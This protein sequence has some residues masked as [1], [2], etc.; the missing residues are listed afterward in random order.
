MKRLYLFIISASLFLNGCQ[1]LEDA[2]P[3]DR[4][5]FMHFYEGAYSMTASAAEATNDG[6]IIAGNMEI[7][8]AMRTSRVIVIKTDKLGRKQWQTTV[9]NGIAS[10]LKAI[11]GGYAIIGSEVTYRPNASDI[12]EL[13]NHN[14]R[15]I[16]INE[17]GS[18]VDDIVSTPRLTADSK[19]IDYQGNGITLDENLN[20]I[21]LGTYREPGQSSFAYVAVINPVTLDTIWSREY[22]YMARDYVNTRSVYFESGQIIWGS[23]INENINAFN[24]SYLAFPV[25]RPNSTF[26][27]SNYYGQNDQ[28]QSLKIRDI[29]K[30]SSG[31]AAIGTYSKPDGKNADIFFIRIDRS[32][33]FIEGSVRYYDV[34]NTSSQTPSLS[35]LSETGEAITTTRDGGFVLAGTLTTDEGKGIGNGG[36]DVWIIKIDAFGEVEWSRIIGGKTNEAVS[37]ILETEDG[38]LLICGTIQ[39]GSEQS[40]GLSSIFLVKTNRYGELKD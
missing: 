18:V 9:D 7:G 32:G 8:G 2:A 30:T 36:K 14:S 37:S 35:D 27:N 3:E 13:E 21:T 29:R 11:N 23:S 5:T 39:D 12:S 20:L 38:G 6:Y 33:R 24:Y 34:I 28:Q 31:Y 40:G 16:L 1:Q 4:R 26:L 22:N 19:H 10:S 15:L 17:N 25:V